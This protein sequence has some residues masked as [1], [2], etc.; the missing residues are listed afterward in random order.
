L[1]VMAKALLDKET[2]G[3]DEIFELILENISEADRSLVQ[4]K[5]DRAREMRFDYPDAPMEAAT[6]QTEETGDST[7][8]S[9][10]GRA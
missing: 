3:T 1:E 6:V 8:E 7:E 9:T 2:M 10:L 4:A 5:F